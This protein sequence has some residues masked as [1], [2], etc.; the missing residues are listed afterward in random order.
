MRCVQYVI[1][2]RKMSRIDMLVALHLRIDIKTDCQEDRPEPTRT[3][4]SYIMSTSFSRQYLHACRLFTPSARWHLVNS[5]RTILTSMALTHDSRMCSSRA[6]TFSAEPS[7]HKQ[8]IELESIRK[9][10]LELLDR[11][12]GGEGETGEDANAAKPIVS[13]MSKEHGHECSKSHLQSYVRTVPDAP[14]QECAHPSDIWSEHRCREDDA[15]YGPSDCLGFAR[16]E[17]PLPETC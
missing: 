3:L 6:R 16:E 9:L 2:L 10:A 11:G 7:N 15:G 13:I 12:H 5:S 8:E 14:F 4:F 17:S 1:G